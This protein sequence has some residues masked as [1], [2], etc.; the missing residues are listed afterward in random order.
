M[1][2]FFRYTLYAL[3]G[4]TALTGLGV[5]YYVMT[6]YIPGPPQQGYLV[7]TGA[8][9]LAGEGLEPRP[10]AV[11]VVRD[12]LIVDVGDA[13]EIE[14]PPGATILDLSGLTLMPGLI[15]LH[16]HLA[17]PD[18]DIGED[19]G[20]T[21]MPRLFLDYMQFFPAKRRAFLAHGVTTVR[22]LGDDYGWVMEMRRML[23]EGE[24]EGPRLY[25]AGPIFTTRQGHPIATI[26]VDPDSDAVRTPSTPDEARQAVAELAGG[27]VRIDLVKVIQERGRPESPLGPIPPDVLHAIVEEAHRHELPVVAHWGTLEDLRD[28]MAAGVDEL[29]HLEPRGSLEAW[30][31]NVLRLMLDRGVSIAPT[32]AVLEAAT[33]RPHSR[34]PPD[35]LQQPMSQLRAFHH[36]GGRVVAGSDA[37]MPGVRSGAG[38]H[39]EL[40]LLVESGLSPG[41]ALRAATSEA[42]RELR[43]GQIGAIVRGG[44]ADLVVLDGDP[45]RQI[46]DVRNVVMVLRDGRIVVDRRSGFREQ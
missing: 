22:S 34:L 25:A 28:V 46:E 31:E 18:L 2:R 35:V 5:V 9:V 19:M 13:S 14:I 43:T 8:T 44:A 3:G 23:R 30:P 1:K 45:L 33:L 12:G 7:L 10:G 26:G 15:D 11:V 4:V 29:Q 21:R 39:R 6:L 27:D 36:A 32:F 16:V 37:G 20:P 38:L 41:D 40:E 17:S 42:A 24:L